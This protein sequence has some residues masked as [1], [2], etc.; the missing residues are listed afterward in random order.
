MVQEWIVL[1][2]IVLSKDLEA[3]RKKMEVIE[4]LPPPTTVKYKKFL[5]P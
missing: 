3:Q 1:G 2:H 4:K 5:R